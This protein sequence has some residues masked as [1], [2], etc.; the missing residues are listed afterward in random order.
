LLV[1]PH[2]PAA[3][4]KSFF[5]KVFADG[6][7]E[8][9]LNF[10]FLAADKNREKYLIPALDGLMEL[11]KRHKGL[12]TAEVSTAVPLDDKQKESL[13]NILSRKINKSVELSVSVNPSLIGGPHIFVDGYYIDW[14]IKSKLRDLTVHMKEGCSA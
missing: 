13:R 10:L 8:D 6:I 2:I 7:N 5:K 14:T 11:I 4:K 3:D 1:H 12:V 9:M